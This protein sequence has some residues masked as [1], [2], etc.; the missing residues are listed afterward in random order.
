MG[1]HP[2]C[3]PLITH[4]KWN[5]SL[6]GA[7]PIDNLSPAVFKMPP[8]R[9]VIVWE[10]PVASSVNSAKL[11]CK[12]TK[13]IY[14]VNGFRPDGNLFHSIKNRFMAH[15]KY[16]CGLRNIG[17]RPHKRRLQEFLPHVDELYVKEICQAR[18]D[19]KYS[20]RQAV[21]SEKCHGR[22]WVVITWCKLWLFSE[23]PQKLP[24][25]KAHFLSIKKLHPII[26][27][28]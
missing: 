28:P 10:W 25:L 6:L 23:V 26:V 2:S 12:S 7:I 9:I 11:T 22:P 17:I 1:S 15:G 14:K 21:L 19:S 16:Y 24:G 4:I 5:Q 13:L 3:S 18:I 27:S 8:L 20:C